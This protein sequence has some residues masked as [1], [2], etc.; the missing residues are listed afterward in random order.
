MMKLVRAQ[1][2]TVGFVCDLRKGTFTTEF[3]TSLHWRI[4]T[5]IF[6]LFPSYLSNF[7]RS[8]SNFKGQD[9]EIKQ[10]KPNLTNSASIRME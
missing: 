2:M 1:N 5:K 8:Q 3:M 6:Q 7:L 10:V 4:N 9:F